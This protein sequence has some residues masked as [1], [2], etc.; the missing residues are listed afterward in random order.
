V[1]WSIWKYVA[2]RVYDKAITGIGIRGTRALYLIIPTDEGD[3]S[4]QAYTLKGRAPRHPHN[5]YLQTWLELGAID[6]VPTACS[7]LAAIWQMRF[8]PPILEGSSYALF[9]V[10]AMVGLSG[11]DLFQTW[12]LAALAF[13]WTG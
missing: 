8:L 11:F 9:A 4:H 1:R 6:A 12:L 3:P 7:R 10:A 13:A 5:I 2:D